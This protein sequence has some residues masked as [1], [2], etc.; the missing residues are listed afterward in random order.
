VTEPEHSFAAFVRAGLDALAREAP[1]NHARMVEI[2]DGREVLLRV[3]DEVLALCFAD[4][5]APLLAHPRTPVVELATHKPV[6]VALACGDAT[7][8]D[9]ILDDRVR[10]RGAIVDLLAFHDALMA[11]LHGAVRSPS[12]PA[13]LA[14]FRR[15][16]Q[17]DRSDSNGESG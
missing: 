4:A 9:A 3:D 5:V 1:C 17:P 14:R 2:L 10:L 11:Y 7:L 6:I 15:F 8:V 16:S 12:S 13:R